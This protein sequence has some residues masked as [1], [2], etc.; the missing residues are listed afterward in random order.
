MTNEWTRRAGGLFGR[1]LVGALL[2]P[3]TVAAQ[4]NLSSTGTGL[5]VG[6]SPSGSTDCR[7]VDITLT[8]DGTFDLDELAF[9]IPDSSYGPGQW[10]YEDQFGGAMGQINPVDYSPAAL[11]DDYLFGYFDNTGRLGL[12]P[13]FTPIGL[14]GNAL[15]VRMFFAEWLNPQNLTAFT[16]SGAGAIAGGGRATFSGQVGGGGTPP[17]PPE[18]IPEPS[19]VVLFA[20]GLAAFGLAVRRR[21]TTGAEA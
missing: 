16:Y 14:S 11:P 2:L 18:V 5:C 7:A 12:G 21:R 1:L 17:P 9:Q 13:L 6:V 4:M 20:A 8:I 15:T 10:V 3:A 19:T